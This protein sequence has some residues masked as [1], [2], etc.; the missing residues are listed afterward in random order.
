MNKST[1]AIIFAIILVIISGCSSLPSFSS[2][3]NQGSEKKNHGNG[4]DITFEINEDFL[5]SL[6]YTLEV[7]NDG[8][9]RIEISSNDLQLLSTKRTLEGNVPI[10][11][12]S[13]DD[14]YSNIFSSNSLVLGPHEQRVFTGTL[15]IDSNY[16]Q[17]ISNEEFD[18]LL[19]I[20]YPYQSDFSTNVELNPQ[21]YLFR[22]AR[23]D[24]SGPLQ[25][26][27]VEG[28]YKDSSRVDIIYEL[29][30]TTTLQ[31]SVVIEQFDFKL[32]TRSLSCQP[33]KDEGGTKV[34]IATPQV[35]SQISKMYFLCEADL[36]EYSS[37]TTTLTSGSYSYEYVVEESK[38]IGFPQS[39]NNR[40]S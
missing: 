6:R 35:S 32:G 11:S 23:V 30:P 40:F 8:E 38:N 28:V 18:L 26:S 19:K 9:K 12:Q 10:T 5:P 3:P 31:S 7:R 22:V 15:E 34:Q 13:L 20:T 36:S 33:Y 21:E 14:F 24:M 1:L 2:S 39:R 4:L 27:S 16:Y 25:L 17:D 37:L 29:K